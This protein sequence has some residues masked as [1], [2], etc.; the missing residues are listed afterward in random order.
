MFTRLR[1]LKVQPSA[2]TATF[3]A[4]RAGGRLTG[5]SLSGCHSCLESS[6]FLAEKFLGQDLR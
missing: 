6:D 3:H 4:N 1:G 2:G 5:Q